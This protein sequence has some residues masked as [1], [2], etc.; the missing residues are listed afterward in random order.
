MPTAEDDGPAL[1]EVADAG[2]EDLAGDVVEEDVD[3]VGRELREPLG[4]VLG[5]VVDDV[6]EPCDVGEPRG[7]SRARRRCRSSSPQPVW[8]AARD[9]AGGPAAPT[10]GR[11]PRGR[12]RRARA[13]RSRRSARSCRATPSTEVGGTPSGTRR[14]TGRLGARVMHVLQVTD[15]PLV[16]R[17]ERIGL[18]P[19][20]PGHQC[21]DGNR[22]HTRSNDLADTVAAHHS[23]RERAGRTTA[24]RSSSRASRGRTRSRGLG[25]PGPL[26][27]Q[28]RRQEVPP[29]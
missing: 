5:L 18:P 22:V 19:E 11:R 27:L 26:R 7:P 3:A 16:E 12:A 23:P 9:R 15:R 21:A 28:G 13:S 1:G 29:R 17:G 20:V 4:D 24:R 25:T 10:R 6:V 2:L 8:R 14:A